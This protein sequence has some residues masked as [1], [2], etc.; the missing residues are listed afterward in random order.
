MFYFIFVDKSL[1]VLGINNRQTL[2]CYCNAFLSFF[3]PQSGKTEYNY[4]YV[5]PNICM[6]FFHIALSNLTYSFFS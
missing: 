5:L 6:T 4:I 1:I 2:I 3:S